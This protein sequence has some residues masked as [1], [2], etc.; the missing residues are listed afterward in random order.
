MGI[1]ICGTKIVTGFEGNVPFWEPVQNQ[2][3]RVNHLGKD[4][5]A[6]HTA[7]WGWLHKAAH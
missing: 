5:V 6:D 4:M 3:F 7:M 2:D 1:S